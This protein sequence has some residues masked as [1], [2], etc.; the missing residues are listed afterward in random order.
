MEIYFLPLGW[1]CPQLQIWQRQKLTLVL[2]KVKVGGF[3]KWLK[4]SLT[5]EREPKKENA[6][7]AGGSSAKDTSLQISCIALKS[8]S[9]HLD[10]WKK[11]HL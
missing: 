1:W 8:V 2:N 5:S 4:G 3:G 11:E 9:D 6:D 7:I 10:E